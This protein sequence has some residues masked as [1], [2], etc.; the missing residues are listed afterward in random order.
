MR[1]RNIK[2]VIYLL[3]EL[4]TLSIDLAVEKLN[5]RKIEAESIFKFLIINKYVLNLSS[6][7]GLEISTNKYVD[8]KLL[9]KNLT[10]TTNS[11]A[12]KKGR[13]IKWIG[14]II[15]VV[16]SLLAIRWYILN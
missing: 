7:T 11:R 13:I 12:N 5:I 14:W 6:K 2:K 9:S 8:Y 10:K 1:K 3:E 15:M 4:D 16:A